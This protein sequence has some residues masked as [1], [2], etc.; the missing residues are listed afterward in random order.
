MKEIRS[1]EIINLIKI[2]QKANELLNSYAQSSQNPNSLSQSF[3]R[4]HLLPVKDLQ[5]SLSLDKNQSPKSNQE[6]YKVNSHKNLISDRYFQDV[7][8]RNSVDSNLFQQAL[9]SKN[10]NL[11]LQQQL[12]LQ[13]ASL[14][15][16]SQQQKTQSHYQDYL[17]NN[18]QSSFFQKKFSS[19]QAFQPFMKERDGLGNLIHS[20]VKPKLKVGKLPGINQTQRFLESLTQK[21]NTKAKIDLRETI[22]SNLNFQQQMKELSMQ[23]N[24]CSKLIDVSNFISNSGLKSNDIGLSS[25]T[26]LTSTPGPFNFNY[27]KLKQQHIDYYAQQTKPRDQGV[28]NSLDSKINSQNCINLSQNEENIQSQQTLNPTQK[29]Q[30][31]LIMLESYKQVQK[32]LYNNTK[33]KQ[34]HQPKLNNYKT[35]ILAHSIHQQSAPSIGTYDPKSSNVEIYQNADKKTNSPNKRQDYLKNMTTEDLL[36]LTKHKQISQQNANKEAN[37]KQQKL[38]NHQHL[39]D[40]TLNNQTTATSS[41]GPVVQQSQ[42]KNSNHGNKKQKQKLLNNSQSHAQ[43]SSSKG[44]GNLIKES[45]FEFHERERNQGL[46]QVPLER[47]VDGRAQIKNIIIDI[48]SSINKIIY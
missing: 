15:Q 28:N 23:K 38:E 35:D 31:R 48:R 36:I 45:K 11:K 16:T 12:N 7:K 26:P 2:D 29:K 27:F 21:L 30:N 44:M 43:L 3:V 40:S 13:Q 5:Q 17:Q 42:V 6:L 39:N 24:N 33:K 1:K 41:N 19:D 32:Q 9:A 10:N 20:E 25:Q 14:Q 8:Q 34:K 37:L 4:K 22:S 18:T 46:A 47:P